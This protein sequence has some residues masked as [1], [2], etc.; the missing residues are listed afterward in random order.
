MWKTK[1]VIE[2]QQNFN[3]SDILG[4][5]ITGVAHKTPGRDCQARFTGTYSIW[6]FKCLIINV[7]LFYYSSIYVNLEKHWTES[8]D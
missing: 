1:T 3:F 5:M 6:Y 4:D 2:F 7:V 8:K